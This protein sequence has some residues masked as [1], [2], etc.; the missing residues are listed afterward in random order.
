MVARASKLILAAQQ[1]QKRY[2]AAV[3]AVNDEVLL[4][5]SGV[6]LKTMSTK[7]WHLVLLDPSRW[8]NASVKLL[9]SWMCH[10]LCGLMMCFMFR[11]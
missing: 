3:F 1:R 6:K 11:C 9:T 4:S 5:T 8:M 7:S 2:Y 10:M